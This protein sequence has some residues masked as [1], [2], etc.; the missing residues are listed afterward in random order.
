M[1]DEGYREIPL[2][3]RKREIV[4]MTIVDEADYETLAAHRW[5]LSNGYVARNVCM[6]DGRRRLMRMHR[7]LLG[8]EIGDPRQTDHINRNKLDNRRLNLRI[9]TNAQNGQNVP[10]QPG[11]SRYRGVHWDKARG[12]WQVKVKLNGVG[13]YLGRFHDEDEAGAVAAEFR[14]LNM[15]FSEEA[16]G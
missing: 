9:A 4:A 10:S 16:L 2:R 12:R 1:Q 7:A 6:P 15:P 8:L 5:H 14:R 11:T 13:H 3:N